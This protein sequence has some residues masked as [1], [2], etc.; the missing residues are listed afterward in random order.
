MKLQTL[1]RKG[2]LKKW[3]I[4]CSWIRIIT[5]VKGQLT[6]RFKLTNRFN[7]ILIKISAGFLVKINKRFLNLYEN[8]RNL[9][10]KIEQFWKRKSWKTYK[11]IVVKTVL[12]W[13]KTKIRD[14]RNRIESPEQGQ[15][16]LNKDA[17]AIQW[18]KN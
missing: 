1:L 2:D 17:T 5:N 3:G 7:I 13:Q 14:Q 15:Q 12:Y 10:K 9:Q 11:A 18:G 4:P 8:S 16:T 6:Y